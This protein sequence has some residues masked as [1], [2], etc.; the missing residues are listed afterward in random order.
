M[1]LE[2]LD[3]KGWEEAGYSTSLNPE[4]WDWIPD[5]IPEGSTAL[6]LGC[7]VGNYG[8]ALARFGIKPI[9]MDFSQSLLDKAKARVGDSAEY[10]CMDVLAHRPYPK[11]DFCYSSGLLEHFTDEE[12]VTILTKSKNAAPV[13]ISLVPNANC[14]GYQEWRKKKEDSGNWEYGVERAMKTMRPYFEEA[15]LTVTEEFS[16]GRD[17]GDDDEKY[18]LVTIGK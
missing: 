8:L 3:S 17:F 14:P 7:G 12:I 2:R 9:L 11:A 4:W 5:Y 15:G 1:S 16:V 10:V 6:E 13:V 18:L